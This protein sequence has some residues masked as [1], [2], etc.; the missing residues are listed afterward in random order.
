MPRDLATAQAELDE[1]RATLATLQEQVRDGDE[2]VTAQQLADQR[3]LISL[4]ELRV[5]AAER[6]EKQAAADDLDA[7]ATAVGDAV[8]DLVGEDS[9]APLVTAVQAVMDAVAGL[10]TAASTREAEIREVAAAA[11]SMNAELGWSPNN[12]LPSDRYGFR[13]QASTFPVSVMALGQGRAVATPVGELLGIALCAALV[14]QPDARRSAA[15]M[16][17]GLQA[18]VQ[19]RAAGVPGLPE[20]LRLT[21]EEWQQLGE[22]GRY[23]ATEQGRRPAPAEG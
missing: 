6:A 3:E 5:T 8:R 2:T 16:M 19:G 20:A 12:P 1:A 18:G 4:A 10:A 22:R 7:R 15:E 11:E 21:A 17:R 9:T 23:E 14:G 13:G